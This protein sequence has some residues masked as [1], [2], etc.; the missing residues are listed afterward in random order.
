[1]DNALVSI[2]VVV[3]NHEKYVDDCIQ[4]I[5]KQTYRNL[6]IIITDDCSTDKSFQKVMAWKEEL[7]KAFGKVQI[8]QTPYNMGAIKNMNMLF[9]LMGAVPKACQHCRRGRF[10]RQDAQ[11]I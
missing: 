6:E 3:Y 7:E 11:E 1:M 2:L 10:F 9:F 4:S 8:I 5:L